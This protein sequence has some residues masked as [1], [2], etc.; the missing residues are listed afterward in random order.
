MKSLVIS[1]LSP[2][3]IISE[4]DSTKSTEGTANAGLKSKVPIFIDLSNLPSASLISKI[5]RC[6]PVAHE[7]YVSD[8]FSWSSKD[9]KTS[10]LTVNPECSP[11]RVSVKSTHC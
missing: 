3:C 4:P 8:A 10:S 6:S 1:Q 7:S 2:V 9:I 5:K 11:I